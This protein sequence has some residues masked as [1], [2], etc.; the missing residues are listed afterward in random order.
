MRL[1]SRTTRLTLSVLFTTTD[2]TRSLG[3]LVVVVDLFG[4]GNV[5]VVV[6]N[7]S[8]SLGV[9]QL[10]ARNTAGSATHKY[11]MSD[12]DMSASADAGIANSD[13]DELCMW[14]LPKTQKFQK[15][16]VEF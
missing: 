3:E 13:V 9:A 16:A 10:V 2:S 6:V 12:L 1:K 11:R 5:G 7:V 8:S 4:V 15:S 14:I